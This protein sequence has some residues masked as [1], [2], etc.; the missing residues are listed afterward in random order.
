VVLWALDEHRLG[1]KPILR[2]AWRKRGSSPVAVIH[3]R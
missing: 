3:P 1:L 2:R